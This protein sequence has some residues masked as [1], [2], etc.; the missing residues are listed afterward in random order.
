[1]KLLPYSNRQ[2]YTRNN[3][4]TRQPVGRRIA[5]VGTTGSGKTTMAR[6][7]AVRLGVPHVE[8]DALNWGPN[9][10]EASREVFRDRTTHALSG[11][12]WTVDGNYSKVRDKVRDIVWSRADTVVWLDYA[13]PVIMWRLVRR[14]YK[15]VV[16]REELWGGNRE[17]IKSA[18]FEKD[19][20]IWWAL[21]TYRRRRREYPVLLNA[22]EHAHLAVVH[23]R[24][25]GVARQWL[26]DLTGER[27]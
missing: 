19:A 10:T 26:R 7:I 9:W 3:A 5:V 20:I 1:M 27:R 16:R 13:L 17:T 18:L 14:T 4:H 6:D 2:S 24:S 15:R 25:P 22:P 12:A 21:R 8:L 11:D 23:L